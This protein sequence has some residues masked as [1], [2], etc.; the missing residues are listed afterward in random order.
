MLSQQVSSEDAY[1][2]W[3]PEDV[4]WSPWVKPILF[5]QVGEVTGTLNLLGEWQQTDMNGIPPASKKK[6]V[7]VDLSGVESVRVGMGL[8]AR[9]YRPVPL[10]NARSGFSSVVN[11]TPILRALVEAT[12]ELERLSIG[13]DAPPTF[14][15][16]ADRLRGLASPGLLDN[17][18]MVFPQDFPS[19]LF[20]Q[21]R[22]IEHVILVRQHSDWPQEDLMHILARWQEAGIGIWRTVPESISPPERMTVVR[23]SQFRSLWYRALAIMGLRRNN[24]GGFGS[25]VPE[26]SSSGS[27]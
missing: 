17:R 22:Q 16:D 1:K 11:M 19:A 2:V 23:P 14:L 25:I 4:P 6:A 21:A 13:A 18:W 12:Q 7:V 15:I 24:A 8:A 20:L 9:G 26:P 10:Y 5:T 3:T 27:G